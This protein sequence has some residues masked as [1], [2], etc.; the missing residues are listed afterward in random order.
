MFGEPLFFASLKERT[1]I[2]QGWSEFVAT[3]GLIAVIAG[4]VRFSPQAVLM[5]WLVAAQGPPGR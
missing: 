4:S 2:A 3:F 5:R 1:G